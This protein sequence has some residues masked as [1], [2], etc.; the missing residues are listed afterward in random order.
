MGLGL[1]APSAL[2]VVVNELDGGVKAH[3]GDECKQGK[4]LPPRT[5]FLKALYIQQP[6]LTHFTVSLCGYGSRVLPKKK[7]QHYGWAS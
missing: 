4:H 2:S 3:H 5:T 1:N 7:T 6:D